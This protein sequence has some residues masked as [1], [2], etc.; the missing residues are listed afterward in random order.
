MMEGVATLIDPTTVDEMS[1]QTPLAPSEQS[2]PD[3]PVSGRRKRRRRRIV[4]L[5]ILT[6]LVGGEIGLRVLADK[7]SKFNIR[8]GADQEW[9]PH[10]KHRW[11]KNV[12]SG[13]LVINSRGFLGAEF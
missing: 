11:K 7:D 1:D 6:C 2:L 9:D 5:S 3:A 12:R 8:L 10:R 4:L 13:D